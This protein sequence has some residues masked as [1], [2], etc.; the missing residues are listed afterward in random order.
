[1]PIELEGMEKMMVR[2]SNAGMSVQK[3]KRKAIIAGA[4]VLRKEIAAN[5]PKSNLSKEHM[6]DNIIISGVKTENGEDYV[7]TGPAEEFYYAPM[8]EH[9]TSKMKEQPFVEPAFLSKKDEALEAM[10]AVVREAILGV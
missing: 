3:V 4:E 10:A 8:V 1:M 9:G 5:A 7:D 2:I 6:K